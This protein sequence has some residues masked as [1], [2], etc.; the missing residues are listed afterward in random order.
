[1]AHTPGYQYAFGMDA[2][3][4]LFEKELYF[5]AGKKL[6]Y[7]RVYAT[8]N[9]RNYRYYFTDSNGV[10]HMVRVRKDKFPVISCHACGKEAKSKCSKCK[11]AHYCG[12]DCQKKDWEKHRD[13]CL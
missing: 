11:K 13:R 2:P 8:Q 6:P 10:E 4:E 12:P 5:D 9:P 7:Y 3:Q 1:M